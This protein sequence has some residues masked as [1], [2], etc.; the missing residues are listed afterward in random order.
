[1]RLARALGIGNQDELAAARGNFLHIRKRLLV[2]SIVRRD[3]DNR[4]RA[5][6]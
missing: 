4:Y 1:V 5:V 2:N 3:H 6:D